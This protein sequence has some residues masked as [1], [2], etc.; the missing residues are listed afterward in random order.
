MVGRGAVRMRK[1][2]EVHDAGAQQRMDMLLRSIMIP[3]LA[4]G[5]LALGV[6][7]VVEAK[8]D[9]VDPVSRIIYPLMMA[10]FV[11]AAA[12]LYRWP[13]SLT[14]ARWATFVAIACFLVMQLVAAM[15]GNAPL[16]GN[17]PFI[18]LLMWLPLAYAFALLMLETHHAPWAALALFA[19][20]ALLSIGH[21]W[22]SRFPE[23]S[24][25][26]LMVNLLASH[27]VLLV[28]LST[29]VKFRSVL[30]QVDV[31]SR[32][33][34]EQASTDPLTGLANRR[35][36]VEML[37]QAALAHTV[38][39]PSAVMLCDLD[40]F[41]GI[42][43]RYGHDAGDQV[44]LAVAAVLQS[45]TRGADTVV[46]WGGDEFLIAVPG[47]ALPALSELAERLRERVAEAALPADQEF[48]IAVSI[49]IG[50][51]QMFEKDTLD[52]W[53]KRA[54]E[55][56]YVAKTGGRNRC[57]FAAQLVTTPL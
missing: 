34:F 41:K 3:L 47:I 17:Y 57:V 9:L 52:S 55:A 30:F 29:L 10:T 13:G 33:L 14:I 15:W 5:A 40:G 45:N 19:L 8:F 36:G 1:S 56:L 27:L 16:V 21:L 25:T 46:R 39:T 50:I 18:S 48:E 32:H 23:S 7:W 22:Q 51:A 28:C 31:R 24:D 53:I 35:Y 37:R 42:N 26:A 38:A 49:S 2:S 11:A 44:V 4:M 12:M 43:D 54:D 20:I 6:L